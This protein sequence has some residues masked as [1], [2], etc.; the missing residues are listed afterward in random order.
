MRKGLAGGKEAKKLSK[1]MKIR[2]IKQINMLKS[3]TKGQFL[4]YR[5]TKNSFINENITISNC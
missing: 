1:K 4:L 2:G 3:G 5:K